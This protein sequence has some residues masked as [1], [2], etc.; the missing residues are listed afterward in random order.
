VELPKDK[1]AAE[2][3]RT[4]NA[5]H[6]KTTNVNQQPSIKGTPPTAQPSITAES[7]SESVGGNGKTRVNSKQTP[8][9][10]LGIQRELAWF[11]GALVVVGFLQF[12]ALVGQVTIYCRQAK[13]MTLQAREM[14]RQ[15]GYMRLTLKAIN[16]QARLMEGQLKEMKRSADN[17]DRA[18]RLTQRADVLLELIE[19]R[20]TPPDIDR[21]T[22]VIVHIKNFGPTR[23]NGLV[24]NFSLF[25]PGILN[26]I[27]PTLI[28]VVLGA[29]DS[30]LVMFQSLGDMGVKD[31]VLYKI[32]NGTLPFYVAGKITY[33][34]VFGHSRVVEC[35]ATFNPKTFGFN[36]EETH[37]D[38]Q[39]NPN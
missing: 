29:G 37:T 22:Q 28:P 33:T 11:T 32:A 36:A 39:K 6:E 8:N 4:I 20:G 1:G 12:F 19:L 34:D 3:N 18:V 13:I 26:T 10:E 16:E 21:E 15:R 5:G 9:E 7:D 17:D 25:I 27:P 35:K 31:D 38:Q 30:K 24:L 23:A 14:K 2:T